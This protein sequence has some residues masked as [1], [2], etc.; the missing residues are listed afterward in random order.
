VDARRVTERA[1]FDLRDDL[2]RAARIRVVAAGKAA[3]GMTEAAVA[4]LGSRIVA[5][6]MTRLRQGY[7]AAQAAIEAIDASHPLPGPASEAAGRAAL[8]LASAAAAEGEPLL[9]LLSG[10]ASAMLASPA[11]DLTIDDKAQATAAMLRAGL[12]IAS[13]N[14]VRRHLSAIKGGQLAAR[15]AGRTITLAISDVC[16]PRDDDPLVIG[17]GPTVGDDSTASDALAVVR[18]H[19]LEDVM[20][21]AVIRH[22]EARLRQ[23]YG[24]AG[25]TAGPVRP[26]DPRLQRSAY[27]VVASRTDAMRAAAEVARRLGYA[28]EVRAAAITGE[29]RDAG[30]GFVGSA[31]HRRPACVI[32]SGETTVTVRGHGRG[33]RNQEL[34]TAALEPLATL[35]PAA[36][37]SIGTDGVDGVTDA[38]GAFADHTMWEKLGDAARAICD[39]VLTRN[40]S[41]SLLDGL[42]ALVRTGPTGTNVGDVQ[43]LLLA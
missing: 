8:A 38:A 32:A 1:L 4:A 26:D 16:V 39:D 18:R 20:P 31:P 40:D 15:A 9:V 34:V 12:D 29:A 3:R 25:G 21:R 5:G 24:A 13:I 23:G 17:S 22:L 37:A 41:H 43:V 10:G 2:A 30:R 7:G 36:L 6:V 19:R 35:G 11:G 33:G 28:V 42:G 14:L 27:W